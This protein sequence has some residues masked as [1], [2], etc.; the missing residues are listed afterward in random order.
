M[1][2]WSHF[3]LQEDRSQGFQGIVI[4][5]G[6]GFRSGT[7]KLRCTVTGAESYTVVCVWEG[8]DENDISG[9][10]AVDWAHPQLVLFS[11]ILF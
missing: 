7:E 10:N 1:F 11:F 6:S 9:A 3:Y 5:E 8:K 2:R 4:R